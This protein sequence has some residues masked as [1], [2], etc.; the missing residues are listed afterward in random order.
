MIND[1]SKTLDDSKNKDKR[2]G[3]DKWAKSP[4]KQRSGLAEN[5]GP[6]PKYTNYYSLTASL[7][8]IYAVIDRSP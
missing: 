5:K 3:E 4:K 2:R 6:F 7:H 1:L 8:Y